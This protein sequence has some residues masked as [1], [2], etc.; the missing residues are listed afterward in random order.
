MNV[1]LS[2]LIA[3]KDDVK[4]VKYLILAVMIVLA[5]SIFISVCFLIAALINM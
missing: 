1:L 5:V 2:F 4:T 3:S